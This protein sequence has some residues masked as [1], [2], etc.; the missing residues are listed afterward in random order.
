[1]CL[2]LI[3]KEIITKLFNYILYF[4]LIKFS[5]NKIRKGLEGQTLQSPLK[6]Y[7]WL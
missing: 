4:L 6:Y 7:W 1:M 3:Y 2:I 5:G